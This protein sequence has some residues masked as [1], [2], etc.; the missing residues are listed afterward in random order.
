MAAIAWPEVATSDDGRA[1]PLPAYDRR[2]LLTEVELFA[3][4]YVPDVID[5]PLTETEATEW[6][7][8]WDGRAGRASTTIARP[9]C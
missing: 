6:L 7:A 2:A 3:S 9:G 1:F 4:W 8:L 5:R